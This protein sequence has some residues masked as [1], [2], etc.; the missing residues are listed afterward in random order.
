MTGEVRRWR[1][2]EKGWRCLKASEQEEGVRDQRRECWVIN[3]RQWRCINQRPGMV[4]A[5]PGEGIV[6]Q[7]D[8]FSQTREMKSSSLETG[9]RP[10]GTGNQRWRS[11][12]TLIYGCISRRDWDRN[13]LW[14]SQELSSDATS[15]GTIEPLTDHSIP[16]TIT[17]SAVDTVSG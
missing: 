14:R 1:H 15:P 5:F 13:G 2:G 3:F 10:A 11:H 7:S 6:G 9:P 12:C 17:Q 4:Q 8:H 16:S